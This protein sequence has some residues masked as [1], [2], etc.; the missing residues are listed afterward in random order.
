MKVRRIRRIG[1]SNLVAL[2]RELEA[3]GFAPGAEVVIAQLEDG[4]LRVIPAS[5]LADLIAG[6]S[7]EVVEDN[8]EALDL[9]AAHD[10]ATVGA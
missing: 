2:P 4:S 1:N 3:Q 9:L 6:I 10:H 8:R 5:Q 7:A